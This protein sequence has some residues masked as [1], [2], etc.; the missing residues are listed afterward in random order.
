MKDR[1]Q[2]QWG[3]RPPSADYLDALSAMP[4]PERFANK[5]N[6]GIIDVIV[7]VGNGR[8][9]AS[10]S[11]YIT[12]PKRMESSKFRYGP[13]PKEPSSGIATPAQD[14][15][16]SDGPEIPSSSDTP[17]AQRAR[18]SRR[19]PSSS[20]ASG[21]FGEDSKP[22]ALNV[23][24]TPKIRNLVSWFNLKAGQR[25]FLAEVL[26][27]DRGGEL[28]EKLEPMSKLPPVER[29]PAIFNLIEELMKGH[30][31]TPSQ[32]PEVDLTGDELTSP[33]QE[34]NEPSSVLGSSAQATPV[35]ST[36][37]TPEQSTAKHKHAV[38]SVERYKPVDSRGRGASAVAGAAAFVIPELCLQSSVGYAGADIHR[39]APWARPG[40]YDEQAFVAGMR[41]V[42][43]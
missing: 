27:R 18:G 35:A 20:F 15:P 11:S 25:Q 8:K 10:T 4:L 30:T 33:V 9:Y 3:V 28:W 24:E 42:V 38:P 7:T 26:T 19:N 34:E 40:E 1:G 37:D 16:A 31:R 32:N 29:D 13:H 6:L 5:S 14:M 41:F 21:E 36:F 2:D 17:L 39:P 12:S 22:K 43:I 23:I